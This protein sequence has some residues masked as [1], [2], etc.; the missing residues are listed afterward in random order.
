[1]SDFFRRDSG[2]GVDNGDRTERRLVALRVSLY[3][4]G[5]RYRRLQERHDWVALL[6]RG[7][8]YGRP[9]RTL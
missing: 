3:K 7:G 5:Q 2:G 4:D 8:L 9:Y 6:D 1:M